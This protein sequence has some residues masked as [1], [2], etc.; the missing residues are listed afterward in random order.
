MN[1]ATTT[2]QMHPLKSNFMKVFFV[3]DRVI[4]DPDAFILKKISKSY[5][6][7]FKEY[8]DTDLFNTMTLDTLMIT[9][10]ERNIENPLEWASIKEFDYEKNYSFLRKQ[11][12]NMYRDSKPLHMCGIIK[13]MIYDYSI[14][15]IYVWNPEDDVRQRF[16]LSSQFGKIKKLK[17]ITGDYEKCVKETKPNILY[18]WDVDRIYKLDEFSE[19]N[20]TFFGIADYGFNFED[21]KEDPYKLRHELYKHKNV[22]FFANLELP[23]SCKYKG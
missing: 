18:D 13:G 17:Y 22:A 19:M 10:M 8:I 21:D 3:Y 23:E 14:G 12:P 11:F 2:V 20:H 7:K 6:N 1:P 16:D 4:K 15:D 5:S 9:L